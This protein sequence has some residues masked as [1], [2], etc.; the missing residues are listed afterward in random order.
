VVKKSAPAISPSVHPRDQF[1][2]FSHHAE[3][4]CSRL[5]V[6]PFAGNEPPVPAQQRVRR[7]DR[8]DF[9]QR[10]AAQPV[11]LRGESLPVVIGESK[12]PPTHLP[13]QD[14]ILFDQVR[15]HFPFT[16]VQPA[17]DC[18]EQQSETRHV[19]HE[20]ELTLAAVLACRTV[21]R[22]VGHYGVG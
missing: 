16:A 6:R 13:P 10:A 19:N 8:R 12:A 7:D 21:G 18:E 22:E 15:Q 2:N 11:G 5:C 4:A 17:G 1:A 3:T 20:P 9:A 14:P